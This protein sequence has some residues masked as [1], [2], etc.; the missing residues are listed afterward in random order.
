MEDFG[1]AGLLALLGWLG[2]AW[3]GMIEGERHG[4]GGRGFLLG[5]FLGPFGVILA[6]LSEPTKAVKEERA[7][8]ALILDAGLRKRLGL[9]GGADLDLVE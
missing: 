7:M 1:C 5:A 6:A 2:M 9:P 4:R 8:R 3:L